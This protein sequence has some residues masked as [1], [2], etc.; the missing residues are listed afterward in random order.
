[1]QD[2]QFY[3]TPINLAQIARK[4][5]KNR[6]IIRLLDPS[7]GDGAL[8]APFNSAHH[9]IK[10]DCIEIDLDRQ[11]ILRAKGY[12]VIDSDFMQFTGAGMYSHIIM[13]PPFAQGVEH[14]LKAFDLLINGELVAILNA[15]TIRNP[16][17]AKRK[18]LIQLIQDFGGEVE[19]IESAFM[20]PDTKIK[21][22]VEVAIIWIEKKADVTQN[23]TQSLDID[24]AAGVDYAGKQELALKGSTI[25]NAVSVFNAAVNALRASEIAQEEAF[26]FMRLLG[27]PLN[28]QHQSD[29]EPGDLQK[30]FNT[31]Y[32]DLK[33][34]AWSNILKSTEFSKYLSSKAYEKLIA[35]FEAVKKLNFTESN[36]RG[37]LLGL[38]NSQSEMNLQMVLD[39]FDSFTKYIPEN[40]AYYR[41][42]KSNLKHKEQAYRL[43]TTRFIMPRFSSS[44]GYM[45]W[46]SF[47]QLSDYDKVFAM[48]DGK[49]ECEVS[50]E[51]LFRDRLA[52]LRAGARLSASYFD[53]RYYK[54]AGTIHFY[55]KNK[56]LIDRMNRLVGKERQWLPQNE[57]H[58]SGAFWNQYDQA[59]KV[60]KNMKIPVQRYGTGSIENEHVA[61][62]FMDAHL[63]ACEKVGIDVAAMLNYESN[64]EAA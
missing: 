11:A 64:Q 4:K 1:M 63:E 9:T 23:F 18:H 36:I 45:D 7:A 25:S 31:G 10:A 30:R 56:K 61:S 34:R 28:S 26:Y 62:Q 24:N 15:E 29:I 60:T 3:P 16:Y 54:G 13:N 57:A 22:S 42:W 47:K 40:R 52:E 43:Q 5:F 17:T 58:V 8:L 33:D 59:E 44:W 51:S 12:N 50:L 46:N 32:D 19:F 21:T 55:P 35:D 53:V 38:V 41:G 27:R 37:F 49:A 6:N 48:L 20:S 39:C 2:L 14:V